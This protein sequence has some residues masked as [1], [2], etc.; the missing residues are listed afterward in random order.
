LIR[1]AKGTI[2]DKAGQCACGSGFIEEQIEFCGTVSLY[3][4]PRNG[5]PLTRGD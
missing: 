1:D 4:R 5:N 2:G 3:L